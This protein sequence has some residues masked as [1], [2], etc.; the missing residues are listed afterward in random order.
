MLEYVYATPIDLDNRWIMVRQIMFG[1]VIEKSHAAVKEYRNR[2]KEFM[3]SL[4]I[5]LCPFHT[6]QDFNMLYTDKSNGKSKR[7]SIFIL[8]FR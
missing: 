6:R 4:A 3:E 5:K 1:A 7:L 8:C 2:T